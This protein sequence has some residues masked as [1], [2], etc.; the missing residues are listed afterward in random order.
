MKA[1]DQ[2][3][4]EHEGIKL[5]LRILEAAAQRVEAGKPVPHEDLDSMAEFLS[6]FADK[7]HHGKE[8]D[9]LFPAL[10]AAGVPRDGG[11]LGVMLHEHT[12]GRGFIAGLKEAIAGLK[13]NR[14]DA[15]ALLA[16]NARQYIELLTQ[17]IE[18]ENTVLFMIADARLPEEEDARLVEAFEEL[19]RERIGPG[20]HEEFHKLLA[21]LEKTYLK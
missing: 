15:P 4:T 10:E 8:E 18:K 14:T 5:M 1:T 20:K 6:V 21:R 9:H 2:L 11:P 12:T 16:S 19:E 3:K 7:C 17:H 13:S